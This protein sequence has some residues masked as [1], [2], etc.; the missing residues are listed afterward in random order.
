MHWKIIFV[1]L[2]VFR[3]KKEEKEVIYHINVPYKAAWTVIIFSHA[4]YV[5]K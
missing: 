4:T 5:L 2:K 3:K 1:M